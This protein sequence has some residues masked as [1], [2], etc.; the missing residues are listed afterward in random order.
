MDAADVESETDPV[1]MGKGLQPKSPKVAEIC[2]KSPPETP[3]TLRD[4]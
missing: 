2:A 3:A 1:L 4:V